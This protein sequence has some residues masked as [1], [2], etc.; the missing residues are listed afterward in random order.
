MDRDRLGRR[1]RARGRP[2]P[3]DRAHALPRH[4]ALPL[5]GDRSALRRHGRRAQ[6]R[7]RQGDDLGLLARPRPSPGARVRRHGRHG[8]AP[9]VR[10]R[11]ARAGARD[12][13]RG[14]RHVR[15]RPAGQGLRRA[16]RGRLRR[17]SARAGHH[18]PCRSGRLGRTRRA[19][20][21]PRRAL[22]APQRRGGGR[23]VG[24][25]RRARRARRARRH[26]AH[27]RPRAR[28]ARGPRRPARPP[29]LL[30]QGDR[31]VPRLPRRARARTRRRPPLR[32]ARA[33][34][35]PRWDLVLA[36]LPGGAREA[37]PGLQR[38]L[39]PVALRRLGPD[40]PVPRHAPGQRLP[41][42]ARGGRRARALPRGGRHRRGARA[43][44]G[45]RQGPRAARARV[46]HG[47]H[48]P[49]GL[50][51]CWRTCRC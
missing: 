10:R 32:A 30:R 28:P 33:R 27:R 25:P 51:R 29:A 43:L 23:G 24:R 15:G 8:L 40:R 34:Q 5:A 3:P 9:G 36:A 17:P 1:G 16:R 49:P 7:H 18:R 19:A 47:A 37:R 11:R 14:D 2:Q 38:L 45:E 21:L 42:H 35:H 50:A 46:D 13:A 26:R 39:L 22:R 31:A 20:R 6:R 48:E 4:G 41:R 12:R 44:Q